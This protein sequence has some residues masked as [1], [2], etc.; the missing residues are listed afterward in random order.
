VKR[1]SLIY[2]GTLGE[3]LGLEPVISALTSLRNQ[4]P[5]IELE[6]SGKGPLKDSL[7]AQVRRLGLEQCVRFHEYISSRDEFI[8]LLSTYAV[9]LAIYKPSNETLVNYAD[10]G[11]LKVYAACGLPVIL[12]KH[13]FNSKE[14]ESSGAGIT[15]NYDET[16]ICNAIRELILDD[17]LFI[18]CRN[19]ASLLAQSYFP[20]KI[21]P[22]A[23]A[24]LLTGREKCVT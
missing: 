8:D 21:F 13:S 2:S 20:D 12:T 19:N 16:E 17:E 4:I 7:R 15:V 23:L 6:I 22:E 1:H 18:S 5:D 9:G 11:K 3:H 14:I 10:I 24:H